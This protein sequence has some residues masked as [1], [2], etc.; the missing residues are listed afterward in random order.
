MSFGPAP[1]GYLLFGAEFEAKSPEQVRRMTAALRDSAGADCV[2]MSHN[3]VVCLDPEIPAS[4]SEEAHR[5]L[6]EE[7][8]FDG[9]IMTDDMA[10]EAVSGVSAPGELSVQ[11]LQA[12]SDLV[13]TPYWE[14]SLKAVG[15]A[16]R[17]G[18]LPP[19]RIRESGGRVLCW[20]QSLGL[21]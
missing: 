8:G 6:R 4:L 17:E 18:R 13:C 19:E 3:T 20:K 1:G 11:A 15:T 5:L 9:V 16:L 7:L 14:E 2:L 21:L 12:G 10:M